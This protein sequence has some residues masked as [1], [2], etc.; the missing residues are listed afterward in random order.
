MN[1]TSAKNRS[2][3]EASNLTSKNV[4]YTPPVQLNTNVKFEVLPTPVKSAS[5]KKE[6]KVIRLENGLTACLIADEAPLS[7]LSEDESDDESIEFEESEEDSEEDSI[8]G[9]NDEDEDDEC[10]KPPAAEQKMAA[11]GLCIGVGSFSDPKSV[12][13]MA[14]FLEH[15]V[16]MGSEKFP[17]ENDFDSFISKRGGSDNAS[18]DCEVTT[19]YFECFEKHFYTALDKF[20]QF[21]IA[22][23]MKRSSI[24]REREAIDS[25]FQMALPSDTYR[26]EQ[27]LVSFARSDCP[28]NSFTWGNLITLKENISEEDLYKGVHEFRKRHY[29]AH[30]M[31]L[32]IQAR[33]PM[34]VLQSYVLD[35]FGNVPTNNL[36]PDDFKQFSDVFATPAFTKMYYVQPSNELTQLELTWALPSLLHKY[37]SKPHQYVSWL[38]GD[39]GKGSLLS[40]LRKKVWALS[41]STGNGESG[42][43][44]NSMYA[45]FSVIEMVFSYINML[46]ELG[47]QQRIYNEVKTI[48]DTSFKFSTEETAVDFVEDLCEAMHFYPPEDYITGSELYFEYDSEAIKTVLLSLIPEKMN[49]VI[50]CNNLPAGLSYDKT[51]KWFGTKYTEKEIPAEWLEKWKNIK[52]LAEFS[53]PPPNP[54]LT[55]DFTILEEDENHPDYPEKVLSTELV[56]LWYRKDQKF[57]L[58]IAFYYLYLITPVSQESPFTQTMMDFFVNLLQIQ[59]IEEAYPAQVA[60]LSYAFKTNDKGI[61]LK[62]SGYNEKL[63]VLIELITKHLV[64]FNS[65]LT[66][67]MFVAV[68]DKLTKY[69]YNCLLKP[70]T[71]SKDIRLNVLVDSYYTM[72]DKY[73]SISSITFEN[74]KQFAQNFVSKLYIKV[75]VQGNVQKEVAVNVVNNFITTLNCQAIGAESYPKFRVIQIPKGESLCKVESF[76]RND[77]NSIVTNYYQSGPFSIRDSVIIEI[78]LLIIQEPLFDTLRTKEQL[79]YHVY[80]SIRETYGILGFTITVNAQATKNSTQYVDSR[81]EKFIKQASDLLVNMSAK[82]FEETKRDL[83]KMKQCTDVHLKEEVN[84]N[85]SEIIDDDYIFDRLKQEIKAIEQ[86][87]SSEVKKWWEKH[88]FC[89]N[90]NNCRKLSV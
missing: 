79:G 19:F 54:F 49:V 50:L 22:P 58:P 65:S 42:S 2:A 52:P 89:G 85:W 63:H 44:H 28:V 90:R 6:Y 8:C 71:L 60:Q 87:K 46:K 7:D 88:S 40:Y 18:T 31:T 81:I 51:E 82:S 32:A 39:E 10:K 20:A 61:T 3:K 84:R 1:K 29:S 83:I 14:H 43:E 30:R 86:L 21:F 12:P 37:K 55:E 75:L 74:M 34:D 70:N 36:P 73:N 38:L 72:V 62:V 5:D 4:S 76:N 25:E 16:F 33:L 64:N 53:I 26:K 41:M 9:M 23:L 57:K 56:E 78:I 48:E 27:L 80:C 17:V 66:E 45:L 11:A 35:C 24:T 47:P 68:K 13:G 77:C 67:D 69:Y 59:L 15:M